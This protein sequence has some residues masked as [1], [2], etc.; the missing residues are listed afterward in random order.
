MNTAT[1]SLAAAACVLLAGCAT[2]P[3]PGPGPGPDGP[4]EIAATGDDCAIF[5]AIAREHYRFHENP[6]PP[7]WNPVRLESGLRYHLTC[8]WDRLGVPIRG[9]YDPDSRAPR[10]GLQWVSFEQPRYHSR[11]ATVATA[12]VHGPLAGMGYECDMVSGFAGWTVR[13][14]RNTWIS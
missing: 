7:V 6:A 9:T 4:P 3:I 8:D 12:L 13:E 11:G 2:P 5:A 14:C 10:D 1:P